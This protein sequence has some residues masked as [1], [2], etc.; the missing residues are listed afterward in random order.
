MANE[1]KEKKG[2][3]VNIRQ[4]GMLFA[5]VVIMALFQFLTGGVLLMPQNVTNL[6][7]QNCYVIVLAVGMLLCIVSS[8]SIDLSVGSVVAFIGSLLG[9]MA[10]QHGV[11]IWVAVVIVL[12]VGFLIGVWQGFWIAYMRIPSFIVTLAGMLIFRGLTLYTLQ[13]LTLSPFKDSFLFISSGFLPNIGN[14]KINV[15]TYLL[16]GIAIAVYLILQIRAMQNKRKHGA[17]NSKMG[18]FVGKLVV[19]SAVI[20]LFTVWLARYKGVPVL[21]I[22]L[23]G[24][25]GENKRLSGIPPCD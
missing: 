16:G 12:A 11:N 14:S 22:I 7:M 25:W 20:A 9:V 24:A 19:V 13:G 21:L 4:Y 10:V 2:S 17:E 3:S 18:F 23:K 1:V 15:T 8:G 6:I 5:L